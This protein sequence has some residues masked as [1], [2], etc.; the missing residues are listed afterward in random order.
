SISFWLTGVPRVGETTSAAAA[1]A[2]P[3]SARAAKNKTS[4]EIR[5]LQPPFFRHMPGLN[6]IVMI[7]G[8]HGV[9]LLPL[10][11]RRLHAAVLVRRAAEQR[12]RCAIPEPGNG[13]A[14]ERLVEGGAV[15]GRLGP[16]PA[17]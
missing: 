3:G 1:A 5:I 8:V 4:L 2:A 9:T 15:Q 14:S 12:C 6:G 13:K 11:A 7:E 17:F 16:A 10:R